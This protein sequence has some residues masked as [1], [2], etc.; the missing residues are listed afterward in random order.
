M[1]TETQTLKLCSRCKIAKPIEGNY[2]ICRKR[3]GLLHARCNACRTEVNRLNHIK[4]Y[5]EE[6]RKSGPVPKI[7]ECGHPDLKHRARGMCSDCWDKYYR[8]KN[9]IVIV[10]YASICPH[11][12]RECFSMGM[13]E[14]C[15]K[16]DYY[17]RNRD[18]IKEQSKINQAIKPKTH[19]R[20]KAIRQKHGGI[21]LAHYLELQKAQ[22]NKC[23]CGFPFD[24]TWAGA[25][26]LDHDHA[27]C[28][29]DA[30]LC[31]LCI[32]GLLCNRCNRVLGMLE[33]DPRLLPEYL[34]I[35]L[36]KYKELRYDRDFFGL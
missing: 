2:N 22:D 36:A 35:Y 3:T 9:K 13:C 20:Y 12:D 29:K 33:R 5:G 18:H 15:Y 19:N 4:K 21:V 30:R 7:N 26:R 24:N 25:P 34:S 14:I 10:K 11:T 1:S 31:G 6:P 17:L 16:A 8:E 23:I 32:R 28:A 27:C